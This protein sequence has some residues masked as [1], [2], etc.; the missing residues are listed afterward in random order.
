MTTLVNVVYTYF[1]PTTNNLHSNSIDSCYSHYIKNEIDETFKN[2]NNWTFLSNIPCKIIDLNNKDIKNINFDVFFIKYE[3]RN[4]GHTLLNILYQ[5]HHYI[6]HNYT[7][8]IVIQKELLNVSKYI[9]SVIQ[10]FVNMENII[11]LESSQLYNFKKFTYTS[12]GYSHLCG[13]EIFSHI[14]NKL[15]LP[16]SNIHIPSN[17][18]VISYKNYFVNYGRTHIENMLIDK[19]KLINKNII[20]YDN[21]C[22]I[23]T[24][25]CVTNSLMHINQNYS[26]QR[27]FNNNYN[28][29]FTNKNYFV[30][31]PSDYTIE[32][33][34]ILLNNAK[35]IVISYGCMSY[36]NKMII[37]NTNINYI[38]LTHK[39]YTHE[40]NF[41]PALCMIPPCNNCILVY[42]LNSELDETSCNVLNNLLN[43]L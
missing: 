6:V 16:I 26:M 13:D 9:F 25:N 39:E 29:Y 41:I 11:V 23:K 43:N 40:F 38:L 42:N 8:K 10:L 35:N 3:V 15:N 28:N 32:D 24:T 36:M 17:I 12:F 33:L 27:S 20:T 37:K 4:A 7:C 34:Y 19:M 22:L 2:I 1:L 18:N 31:N 5:I 21:I 14:N 30:F